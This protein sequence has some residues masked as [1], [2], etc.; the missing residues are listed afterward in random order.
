M[1]FL[2]LQDYSILNSL[3]TLG[4]C[5]FFI[6]VSLAFI[7]KYAMD[8]YMGL[9]IPTTNMTRRRLVFITAHRTFPRGC[10]LKINSFALISKCATRQ[11]YHIMSETF[12]CHFVVNVRLIYI[13]CR[14]IW[15][16]EYDGWFDLYIHIYCIYWPTLRICRYS[17]F[18]LGCVCVCVG[19]EKRPC[20]IAGGSKQTNIQTKKIVFGY[21]ILIM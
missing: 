2:L 7:F 20:F 17:V 3:Q 4:M 16:F 9:H 13:P 12:G 5:F 11:K 14:C 8:D 19:S 1:L 18:S 6:L 10:F 15:L 21:Q